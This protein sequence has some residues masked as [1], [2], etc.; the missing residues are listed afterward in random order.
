MAKECPIYGKAIYL[1]C[2]ECEERP[3]D[4]RN[5]ANKQPNNNA[6]NNTNN[7]LTK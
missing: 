2:M 6:I 3:C 7:V 1:Y 5:K 4:K